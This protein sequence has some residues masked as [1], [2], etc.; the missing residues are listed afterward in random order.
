M[1]A[2]V[3][4]RMSAGLKSRGNE[5]IA[6]AG[7]TPSAF[8]NEV[9]SYIVREDRLPDL[10]PSESRTSD[11]SERARL[12]RELVL[13]TVLPVPA[14]FWENAPSDDDLLTSTLEEKYGSF[15]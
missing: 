13:G 6:R 9:Y 5:I 7:K 10:L 12:Y 11:E 8:I 4:A 2:M 15:A 3:T 1:D 14:T